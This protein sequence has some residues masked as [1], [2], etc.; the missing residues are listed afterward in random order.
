MG[1]DATTFILE[2]V[3]FLVL[4]WLMTRFLYRPLQAAIAK[5]QQQDA[6]A[7]Q[8]LQAARAELEAQRA[9]LAAQQADQEGLRDAAHRQLAVEIEA[10]RTRQLAKL[11]VELDAERAR[12]EARLA[13]RLAQQAQQ[14]DVAAAQRAQTFLRGYLERLAGPELE[15]AIIRLFLADLAALPEERRSQLL[16][17]AAAVIEVTSAYETAEPLRREVETALTVQLGTASGFRWQQEPALIAGLAVRLNGHLL[18]AS[19]A[20]SLEAFHTSS[21]APNQV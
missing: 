2:I 11:D 12:A 5:R 7:R 18:E 14:Q 19:L 20:K 17:S 1:M 3:N 4:L 16:G 8:S 10:E 9:Q 15:Q 21:L 6:E 13:A